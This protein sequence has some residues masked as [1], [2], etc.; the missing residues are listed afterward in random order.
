[1]GAVPAGGSAFVQPGKEILR[2]RRHPGYELPQ[3]PRA[4]PE[5]AQSLSA[6]TPELM[7]V[8]HSHSCPSSPAAVAPET[9]G[10]P[11]GKDPGPP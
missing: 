5:P 4:S 8:T 10:G 3:Q 1:M 2:H 9:P 11:R 6:S 7:S